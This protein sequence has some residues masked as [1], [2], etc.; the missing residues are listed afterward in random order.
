MTARLF[1]IGGP[2]HAGKSTLAAAVAK[3]LD[4]RCISTDSLARHPGRP[5]SDPPEQPPPHVVN[6]YRDLPVDEMMQSVLDHYRS[7]WRPLV[8]PLVESGERLVL[9]GSALLPEVVVQLDLQNV[10][11]TWLVASHGLLDRRIRAE[12]AYESRDADARFLIDKFAQRAVAFSRFIDREVSR[13]TLP[14]TKI[15]C[16]VPTDDLVQRLLSQQA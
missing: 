6:H 9:E 8:L 16:D 11:A 1:L 15:H 14:K 7:M 5:W 13:L 10:Q 3:H 12:S 2:S 4:C